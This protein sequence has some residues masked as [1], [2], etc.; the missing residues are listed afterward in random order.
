MLNITRVSFPGLGIGEFDMDTVAFNMFGI[1]IAWYALFI[2]F[3][4]VVAVLYVMYR[5]NKINVSV[6]DM[7][8]ILEIE[9]RV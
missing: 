1:P 9:E 8:E 7:E 4:M 5:A 6:D 2:T 3:G